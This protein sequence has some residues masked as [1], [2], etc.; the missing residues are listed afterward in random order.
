MSIE[1]S[2]IELPDFG[3]PTVEPLIPS[4][5]YDARI[6]T[7]RERMRRAKLDALIVYG[8]REHFANL[9]WL[10]GYDPR[11]EESLGVLTAEG[12]PTLL[13]GNEGIGYAGLSPVEMNIVLYQ[14]FSLL[15]QPRDM[16]APLKKLLQRSGV[17]FDA[18]V[19]V[20]GWKYFAKGELAQHKQASELPAF[21][22]DAV[23][24]T[25][26]HGKVR[27]ASALFMH[28]RD[29]LRATNSVHQLARFEHAATLASQAH[30][31]RRHSSTSRSLPPK[32]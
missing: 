25:A 4:D 21:V 10:T 3:L 14:T 12:K 23:R 8:D 32:F 24:A 28:P 29:G 7:T 16:L 9:A 11:F 5:E 6:A 15:A 1:L 26:S 19:G 20:V 30:S 13:V 27:N 31:T 17:A 22:L 18:R 2:H